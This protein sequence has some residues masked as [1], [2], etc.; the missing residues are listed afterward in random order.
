MQLCKYNFSTLKNPNFFS[1]IK[2]TL[3][4]TPP[5]NT[6]F[7]TISLNF[8]IKSHIN[9]QNPLET[10]LYTFASE[11]LSHFLTFFTINH[12][13]FHND[14]IENSVIFLRCEFFYLENIDFSI[15]YDKIW[16]FQ[17]F[18]PIFIRFLYF[19]EFFH[20]EIVLKNKD[21]ILFE[22]DD[23]FLL[24]P[25]LEIAI[26]INDLSS[27]FI[28]NLK[29]LSCF[30]NDFH[31]EKAILLRIYCFISFMKTMSFVKNL[32]YS[33]EK[34]DNEKLEKKIKDLLNK[35]AEKLNFDVKISL[36][37][38]ESPSFNQFL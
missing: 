15:K 18:L 20:R 13:N 32:E 26:F 25:L 19:M 17:L 4:N 14:F 23:K 16:I 24:F 27:I 7:Q 8:P 21:L 34:F 12:D 2:E 37:E 28:Q 1:Q 36:E 11:I 6:F 29:R 31:E 10:T 38:G 30:L 9:S 35:Q 22:S 33:Q 3:H 5:F